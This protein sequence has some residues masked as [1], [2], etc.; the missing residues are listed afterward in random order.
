MTKN[1]DR[2][3]EMQRTTMWVASMM[4]VAMW[5]CCNLWTCGEHVANTANERYL[6]EHPVA[7]VVAPPPPRDTDVSHPPA[8]ASGCRESVGWI[9]PSEHYACEPDQ[10]LDVEWNQGGY[11]VQCVC[12]HGPRNP[13]DLHT[14]REGRRAAQED[15]FLYICGH[16]SGLPTADRDLVLE[17]EC[18]RYFATVGFHAPV[19]TTAAE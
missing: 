16:N 13:D 6:A 7:P 3:G 9:R 18:T 11:L 5:F 14:E 19:G 15:P 2:L 8:T 4:G 12:T 17:S 1:S 10:T